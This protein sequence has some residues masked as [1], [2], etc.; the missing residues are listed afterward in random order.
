MSAAKEKQLSKRDSKTARS[1]PP[2]IKAEKG[3]RW[4][5]RGVPAHLQKAA[6]EAAW[7]ADLT[8]GAWL[9][10]LVE[11]AV[12]DGLPPTELTTTQRFEAIEQR[13]ERLERALN[14]RPD[15]QRE[16]PLHA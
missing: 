14:E 3:E 15:Q 2:V 16:A 1:K 12:A 7:T 9:T 13:L 10:R 5:V 4:T 8:V 11:A 6:A